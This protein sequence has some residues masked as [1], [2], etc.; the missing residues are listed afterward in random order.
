MYKTT[1]EYIQYTLYIGTYMWYVNIILCIIIHV[2]YMSMC[3]V[4]ALICTMIL[5]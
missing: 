4:S 3:V 2:L 1:N 5:I